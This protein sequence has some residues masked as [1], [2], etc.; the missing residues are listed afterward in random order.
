[1]TWM[2]RLMRVFAIDIATCPMGG[3][4]LCVIA[5]IDEPDVIHRILEPIRTPD[6]AIDANPR[7]PPIRNRRLHKTEQDRL[8]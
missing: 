6:Q 7:A 4:K 2:Q 1:M 5:C 8:F 3:S